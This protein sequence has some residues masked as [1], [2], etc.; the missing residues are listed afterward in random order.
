MVDNLNKKS[1]GDLSGNPNLD[2]VIVKLQNIAGNGKGAGDMLNKAINNPLEYG[3]SAEEAFLIQN[4]PSLKSTMASLIAKEI[5]GDLG[6]QISIDKTTGSSNNSSDQN[7][8]KSKT[9][10]IDEKK[11]ET[12]L[13]KD[14]VHYISPEDEQRIQK[15]ATREA[16]KNT[17]FGDLSRE[18]IAKKFPDARY[19]EVETADGAE[20]VALDSTTAIERDRQ[21]EIEAGTANPE[22]FD[23]TTSGYVPVEN[24]SGAEREKAADRYERRGLGRIAGGAE[25]FDKIDGT[26]D[27]FGGL[28][29]RQP[30]EENQYNSVADFDPTK[31]LNPKEPQNPTSVL[32]GESPDGEPTSRLKPAIDY[33]DPKISLEGAKQN[34]NQDNIGSQNSL[35]YIKSP[36]TRTSGDNLVDLQNQNLPQNFSQKTPETLGKSDLGQ[37]R[38]SINEISPSAP[39]P[40]DADNPDGNIRQK[41]PGE[42]QKLAPL[43]S[44]T[45]STGSIS[46]AGAGGVVAGGTGVGEKLVGGSS[47]PKKADSASTLDSE[48][49]KTARSAKDFDVAK[50]LSDPKGYARDAAE[51]FVKQQVKRLIIQPIIGFI[52]SSLLPILAGILIIVI[53]L[54]VIPTVLIYAYCYEKDPR[55]L[56]STF[57]Y[58]LTGDGRTIAG[59][60]GQTDF[61]ARKSKLRE[62][63]EKEGGICREIN[64]NF[65]ADGSGASTGVAGSNAELG[66]LNTQLAGKT[67]KDKITLNRYTIEKGLHKQEAPV[68]I[69]KEIIE[70]GTKAGVTTTTI[71]FTISVYVTE[72]IS[73]PNPWGL[74]N[75]IGCLGIAQICPGANGYTPWTRTALGRVP[76]ATEFK[77]NREI[78]MKTIQAGLDD[79]ARQSCKFVPAGSSDIFKRSW[80]WLGCASAFNTS[81]GNHPSGYAKSAELNFNLITCK[82]QSSGSTSGATTRLEIFDRAF[83]DVPENES[84]SF[85]D[86]ARVFGGGI[87]AQAQN[88]DDQA[89]RN[90]VAD[91]YK[92]GQV[93]QIKPIRVSD[94]DYIR[95][96][97]AD[98]NLVRYLAALYDSGIVWVGSSIS[99]GRGYGG[100]AISRSTAID[101][102]GLGYRSDFNGDKIKGYTWDGATSGL[103]GTGAVPSA[104]G[105]SADPRIYRH[106]DIE[107]SN[108]DVA[109]KVGELFK[110]AVDI[111][112]SSGVVDTITNSTNQ[113]FANTTF[114][115][116]YSTSNNIIHGENVAPRHHHHLHI[117]FLKAAIKVGQFDTNPVASSG[118]SST[119]TSDS[120]T[121]CPAGGTSVGSPI[122]ASGLNL[123]QKITK[124][125]EL[126]KQGKLTIAAQEY[127]LTALKSGFVDEKTIDTIIQIASSP[128]FEN[129]NVTSLYRDTAFSGLATEKFHGNNKRG[130]A[131]D[132]GS[133][134]KNGK[135]YSHKA[136]FQNKG[137][138]E[139]IET[140]VE[141]AQFLKSTGNVKQIITDQPF[142]GRLRS[143]SGFTAAS[144]KGTTTNIRI[145]EAPGHEDHFH[146]DIDVPTKTTSISITKLAGIKNLIAGNVLGEAAFGAK[147]GNYKAIQGE[148]GHVDFLKEI[149]NEK[150]YI[151][152]KDAGKESVEMKKAFDALDVEAKKQ[153]IDLKN[154][155]GYRS[156]DSQVGTFFSKI[157]KIWGPK[158]TDTE[159]ATVKADYLKRAELSAPPGFSEHSTGLAIDIASDSL[160]LGASSN[161]NTA[162]YPAKLAEFLA[163]NAPKFGFK[164][165]YPQGSTAG[166][167]YEPWHWV[168]VGNDTYKNSTPLESFSG[169]GDP[170]SSS[171]TVDCNTGQSTDTAT[172]FANSDVVFPT[173]STYQGPG[174]QQSFGACRKNGSCPH[175]GL[176]LT[177]PIPLQSQA[178]KVYAFRSGTVT[179][180]GGSCNEVTINH[181]DGISTRYLHNKSVS[182]KA[183]DKVVA[184]QEIAVMGLACTRVVH[185]HFEIYQNGQAVNPA[186]LLLDGSK[187][188]KAGIKKIGDP[189]SVGGGL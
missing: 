10:K 70:A 77:S 171:G 114:A 58:A 5:A 78:Q 178:W 95:N 147:P 107:S 51:D 120:C 122:N 154:V 33:D 90:K 11:I 42:V 106:V 75:D 22:D 69:I 12:D 47:L 127:N 46:A 29:D 141:V 36:D 53:L 26:A 151:A 116:K 84:I 132:I 186:N 15:E 119:S 63:F 66:C 174:R 73:S 155:S 103:R 146:I 65:C 25:G 88:N 19:T 125:E 97:R 39:T 153:G 160:G 59:L 143:T 136:I 60:T 104:S 176:D 152:Y 1:G 96:G 30:D 129:I 2:E 137:P 168:F 145:A 130:R 67:D 101:I 131:F 126:I 98:M 124:I 48:K 7:K 32:V 76:S 175:K 111:G 140:W 71:A 41:K 57:E 14:S 156:Y 85:S 121:P 87:Q 135:T 9:E 20:R 169:S 17:K 28:K 189:K 82:G 24:L 182:V 185:L 100:H 16:T 142:I 134:K 64:P 93:T 188:V 118:S 54:T 165:S 94:E 31:D 68:R 38:G 50:A 180:T 37:S 62:Y 43:N 117:S 83:A 173:N 150:K 133:V 157:T 18:E 6:E 21:K 187:N 109:N 86:F 181:G 105:N 49:L 158:L 167:G 166:A 108:K 148:T 110:K 179:K 177:P 91:L 113:V 162:T 8:Q 139:G 74:G 35:G 56:R 13:E 23:P 79:K 159:K 40:L 45:A 161:L 52:G 92:S 72:S 3:F 44:G 115:R 34:L 102:W 163:T 4:S 183:G 164:L 80:Q 144:G 112:Y 123:S 138:Q 149:A 170:A 55:V 81:G 184:G 61:A 99:F 172:T 128:K 27:R 89:L